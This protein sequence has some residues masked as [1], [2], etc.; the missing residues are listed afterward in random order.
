MST[1][2]RCIRSDFHKFRHTGM[3]WIHLLIP[4][5]AAAAFLAYYSVS[6]WNPDSKISSYF[7]VI[8]AAFPLIISLVCSK[9]IEQE[10]Q[11]GSFQNI[12]CGIK[13]RTAVYSS[14][15]TIMVLLGI[16]SIAIA[17][18]VFAVGFKTAPVI[19]Y[20]KAA[21]LLIAGSVFLYILHLFTSLQYGRGASI[22]LGIVE[23]L[24]SALALTGLG[25]RI[26]Y[27][28]PCTWSARLCDYLVYVWMH[29]ESATI[30]AAELN[31]WL[32]FAILIT[33]I[34]FIL[35]LLWFRNW[36]GRR[37]YD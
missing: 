9:A 3:L 34:S 36:E 8:G 33:I 4:L 24:I 30:W 2:L 18:G 19:M 5:A 22:G 10:G 21:G 32:I 35:S 26:W 20:I 14:K 12:L 15:L 28:L 16:F 1:L 17:T 6:L 11:A 7:E 37:T 13:S 23:S 29:P 31:R 27:Y 25:D